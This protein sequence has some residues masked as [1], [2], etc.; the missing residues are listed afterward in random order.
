M[1]MLFKVECDKT[2]AVFMYVNLPLSSPPPLRVTEGGRLWFCCWEIEFR[3]LPELVR[4]WVL[5]R[6]R[7]EGAAAAAAGGGVGGW[8]AGMCGSVTTEERR[9]AASVEAKEGVGG[10]W[11]LRLGGLSDGKVASSGV[12]QV[13]ES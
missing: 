1:V 4:L 2:A 8:A 13:I 7:R 6:R 9:R 12:S 5:V 3:E 10:S 11:T